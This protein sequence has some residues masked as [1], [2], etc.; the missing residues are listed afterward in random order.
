MLEIESGP[1]CGGPGK[2][3]L[4]Q[5]AQTFGE[6]KMRVFLPMH[7]KK[8]AGVMVRIFLKSYEPH[9]TNQSTVIHIRTKEQY[10]MQYLSVRSTNIRTWRCW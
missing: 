2:R 6:K 10:S 8:E 4:T 7:M 3:F 5:T 1:E 9:A